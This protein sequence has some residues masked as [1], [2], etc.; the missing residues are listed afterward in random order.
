MGHP[1]RASCVRDLTKIYLFW[2][3]FE[4]SA[5]FSRGS[6]NPDLPISIA[7]SSI[8]SRK[9]PQRLRKTF[10]SSESAQ[11]IIF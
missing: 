9:S 11:V 3:V 6:E 1:A 10:G 4:T 5:A 8:C 7:T 2:L